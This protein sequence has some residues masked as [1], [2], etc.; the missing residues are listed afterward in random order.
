M[1]YTESTM[2]SLGTKA[3]DF[4]L[5]D[6]ISGQDIHLGALPPASATLVM[7]LCNHCPYVLHVNPEIVRLEAAFAPLGVRF[8]GISAND[9]EKYPEDGPENMTRHAAET[10]YRFPYLYDK[11]QAVAKAYDA[12]CTPDF[13]LFDGGLRLVYRGRLDAS[14][15]SNGK[16]LDGADLRRAIE[17]V[18][19]G[20]TP[21]SVQYPS[22]GC[23]IK[24]K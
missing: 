24:W 1:A 15:P 6:T 16:S 9:A 20:G 21:E 19:K 17:A 23:N 7:F 8:L 13:Y 22:G 10:G 12:A 3:P 5:P 18:L 2:L 11:S 14:R 4:T